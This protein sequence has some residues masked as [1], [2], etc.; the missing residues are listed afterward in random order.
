[1]Q[2]KPLHG[3][4]TS[5]PPRLEAAM[6]DDQLDDHVRDIHRRGGDIGQLAGKVIDVSQQLQALNAHLNRV[7]AK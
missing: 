3:R 4:P 7:L 6:T 1:M 5:H 2:E